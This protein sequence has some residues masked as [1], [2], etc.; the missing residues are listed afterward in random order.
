MISRRLVSLACVAALLTLALLP[1]SAPMEACGPF[2]E[3]DTFVRINFPDDIASFAEGKLGIIQ[4]GFDSNE[5]AVAYRYL[6][7]GKL[8]AE[9]EAAYRGEHPS[10]NILTPDQWQASEKEKKE[11][12]PPNVWLR[13]RAK[14]ASPVTAAEPQPQFPT[15]YEGVVEFDPS[16][17]NCPDPA[18][19]NAVLTLKK[20]AQTWGAQ[21]PWLGDWIHGQDVVFSNCAAKSAGT[22]SPVPAGGPALLR[23][24]RAYQLAAAKFYAKQFDDAAQQFSAIADDKISPW[25]SWGDYLAARATVR[26]AFALGK[27]TDPYSGDLASYDADTMQR[28]QQMLEALLRQPNPV[29]SRAT[30]EAELNF[31]RIRTEPEQRATEICAAL[32]G[33]HPDP[34]FQQDL[35][36]V[37]WL[38]VKQIHISKWPPLYEW[39]LAWRNANSAASSYATWH[40]THALPWFVV[41]MAKAGPTDPFAPALLD[42]AAKIPAGSPAFD[43]VFYHRV[44]LLVLLKRLDEAR[45]LLDGALPEFRRDQPGS[46]LNALLGVRMSLA[47]NFDEFLEFAPRTVLSSESEGAD[48]LRAQCNGQ[49]NGQSRPA[50]CPEAVHPLAFDQDAAIV[51]NRQMP[52]QKL[53][54]AAGSPTLPQNL[55]QDLAV[56]AWTRSVLL[57]DAAKAAQLTPLLPKSVGQTA[58]NDVGFIADLAILRNWGVRPFVEPG[59]PR[60]ASFSAF[61]EFRDNWW[62]KPWGYSDISNF[63][64]N[65]PVPLPDFLTPEEKARGSNEWERLQQLPDSAVLIGQRVIDYARLHPDDPQLPEALALTVRATHYACQSPTSNTEAEQSEY[66][67]TGEAAFELLHHRYPKS[68]WTAK[69]PYYY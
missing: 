14:Y 8:S 52:L 39:I 56:M 31:V 43:T 13:E 18:F 12:D 22:P 6:N 41:A 65:A 64:K 16:Y 4:A 17:V 1:P 32:A 2:F 21:S 7:G 19:Q 59:I 30:V 61:D 15:N 37:S 58:G 10:P 62:C 3:E 66:T 69:T 29:P 34:N 20:R 26:K 57:Q 49:G 68:P 35:A 40:R 63:A 24:D 44:R 51:L 67:P 9:E 45:T 53:I 46:N 11:S 48:D 36:D 27:A 5:Y 42:E 47:R 50:D 38:F 33:P 54:E 23:A 55:R 28:A 25:Q 60:V